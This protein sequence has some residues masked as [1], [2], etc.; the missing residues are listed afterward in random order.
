MYGESEDPAKTMY[1]IM[2]LIKRPCS[3]CGKDANVRHESTHVSYDM[4]GDSNRVRKKAAAVARRM[5]SG[6]RRWKRT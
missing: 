4:A 6:G 3:S 5:A 2:D 1:S